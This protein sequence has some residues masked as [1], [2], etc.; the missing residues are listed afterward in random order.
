MPCA[1]TCAARASW[2]GGRGGSKGREGKGL[3]RAFFR[4]L[5]LAD[6]AMPSFFSS[7]SFVEEKNFR[8]TARRRRRPG[9]ERRACGAADRFSAHAPRTTERRGEG[10]GR[11][12]TGGHTVNDR[13]KFVQMLR[14]AVGVPRGAA[15]Q[16]SEIHRRRG[17]GCRRA[18]KCGESEVLALARAPERAEVSWPSRAPARRRACASRFSFFFSAEARKQPETRR[19]AVPLCG[20]C[21]NTCAQPCLLQACSASS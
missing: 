20:G 1:H 3:F 9:C 5:S 18:R 16:P 10:G 8:C 21:A 17:A 2:H 6:G 15:L 13:I 4:L 7:R 11:R 14:V 19:A 12:R